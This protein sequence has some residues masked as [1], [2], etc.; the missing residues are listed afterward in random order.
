MRVRSLKGEDWQKLMEQAAQPP[1]NWQKLIE[2]AV[3]PPV[4]LTKLNDKPEF[5]QEKNLSSDID[6][7]PDDSQH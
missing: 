1:K 7:S 3:Q 5:K 6:N 2:Q 4:D